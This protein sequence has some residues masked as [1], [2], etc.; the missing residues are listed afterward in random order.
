MKSAL[1]VTALALFS[2]AGCSGADASPTEGGEDDELNKSRLSLH[3][4][5]APSKNLNE[6]NM[7]LDAKVASSTELRTVT[8]T[9]FDKDSEPQTETGT[10]AKEL[11]NP[12]YHPVKYK[13]SNQFNL[14]LKGEDGKDFLPL[15]YCEF[16]VILPN[17]LQTMKSGATFQG[18]MIY[19]CDQNG[20][21]T[22]YAC[23]LK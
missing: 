11:A 9:T 10:S 12:N 16:Q 8:L 18:R 15:D 1:I 4:E 17:D 23:S 14:S 13:N 6:W 20:G 19:H 5:V 7:T 3:C 21:S 22:A 2:L